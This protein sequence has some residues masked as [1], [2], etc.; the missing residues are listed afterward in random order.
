M[1]TTKIW[2]VQKR[3][4]KVISYANNEEKTKNNYNKYEMD[5]FDDIRQVMTYATNPDKTK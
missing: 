1:E 5:K 4:D 2:K 3:I